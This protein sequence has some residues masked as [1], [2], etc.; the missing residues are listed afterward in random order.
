ML[1]IFRHRTWHPNS[2]LSESFKS[3]EFGA[4]SGFSIWIIAPVS[5][6][7]LTIQSKTECPSLNMI[8]AP[9]SVRFR[10]ATRPSGE[11][12]VIAL[13]PIYHASLIWHVLMSEALMKFLKMNAW[14]QLDG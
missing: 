1:L 6:R 11:D 8:L 7:F 4:E 14:R 10:I 3:K 5:D 12:V 9:R 13:A 2:L